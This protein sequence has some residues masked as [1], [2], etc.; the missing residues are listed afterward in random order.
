M[1]AGELYCLHTLQSETTSHRSTFWLQTRQIKITWTLFTKQRASLS[2]RS[3]SDRGCAWSTP[4]RQEPQLFS[5]APTSSLHR[6]TMAMALRSGVIMSNAWLAV[7]TARFMIVNSC[8]YLLCFTVPKT[9]LSVSLFLCICVC[10]CVR[11]GM[12]MYLR[13]RVHM[14]APVF[15]LKQSQ[16]SYCA[17]AFSGKNQNIKFALR[18]N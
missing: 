14:R 13:T 16:S 9:I 12:S 6:K 8:T 1:C 18:T 3:V 2:W 5:S 4:S 7:S 15:M 17:C 11:A 10:L